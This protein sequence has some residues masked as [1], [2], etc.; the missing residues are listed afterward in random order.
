LIEK[1]LAA[2]R[3]ALTWPDRRPFRGN[4][5]WPRPTRRKPCISYWGYGLGFIIGYADMMQAVCSIDLYRHAWLRQTGRF[6]MYCAPPGAWAV[7]FA[8]TGKP[9]H[10][11]I[12]TAHAIPL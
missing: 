8:D 4:A 10:S 11:V 7:S 3:V 12:S 2:A 5:Q 6:P 1:L 9:N